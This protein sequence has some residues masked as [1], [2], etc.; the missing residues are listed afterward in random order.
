MNTLIK[1]IDWNPFFQVWQLRGRYPNRGYPK[2][3][4]DE[5]V[6]AEAKKL[7]DEAQALLKRIIDNKLLKAKGVVG[8]YPANSVG[9]D[10]EVYTDETRTTVAAKFYGLRQQAEKDKDATDPYLCISDFI[11]PKESGI[12]D[13]IGLFAVSSGFGADELAASYEKQFDDYN[14]IMV[15]ALADRLAEAFAE[16]LHVELRRDYWGYQ[17]DENLDI[18]AM[19]SVKYQGIRPAPG[20][21][22][23]PDHTEKRVMWQLANIE[24]DTGIQLTDSL[25]M[26]PAASVSGL[27]FANA[28]SRYFAV[29]K[30]DKDQVENYAQRKG[31]SVEEVEKW[32]RPILAYES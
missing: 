12:A 19:L 5:A 8:L 30:I 4:K 13:Y 9:D 32:L 20:Y 11:A 14:A 23:Q 26:W 31:V 7:Y 21:P 17:K 27:Y 2:I 24:R 1:Y 3:F 6:G 18:E 22:S 10:I 29:G 15:K 16:A 25:A 28:E